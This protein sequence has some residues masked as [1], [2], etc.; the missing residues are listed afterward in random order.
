MSYGM[1]IYN[2]DNTLAYDSTSQGGVF[3]RFAELEAGSN[4]STVFVIDLGTVTYGKTIVL[5]PLFLGDHGFS[6]LNQSN[7]E[8]NETAKISWYNVTQAPSGASAKNNTIIM[9][10]A[11]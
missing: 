8:I 6:I 9:V 3:L 4:T 1:K 7:V 10:F 11:K 5:Y 2:I